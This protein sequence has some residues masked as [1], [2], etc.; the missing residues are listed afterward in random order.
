[1]LRNLIILLSI[2]FFLFSCSKKANKELETS[3]PDEKEI[4]REIYQEAVESLK[5][6]DSF[7]ASK[8]FKEAESLLPISD[9]A[10]KAALMSGFALYSANFYTD[11]VFSLE[12]YIRQYPTDKNISYA[13]YLIGMCYYEQILDEKKD[14]RPLLIAK[15]KFEFISTEYPNTD[16]AIDVKFKLDLITDQLAA[17]EMY[18]AR[19]YVKEEK[20]IPAINRFKK[21]VEDYDQTIF[22]EEALHRLV[23]IYYKIGLVEEAKKTA[24]I[25]G[26]NYQSSKWYERSYTVFNKEY[27]KKQHERKKKADG[28]IK[29]KIKS[30]FE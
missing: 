15:K 19:H 17:K 21:I 8:K 27:K 13:H 26:Y 6:G 5:K 20:W 16:Y 14:L 25:L 4:A 3:P 11:S 1:M 9:W 23:E 12:R 24:V 22:I 7:Y 29:K 28:F 2:V 10:A 30:L 18:V